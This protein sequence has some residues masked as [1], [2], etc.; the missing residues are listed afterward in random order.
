MRWVYVR[1]VCV[2]VA[3]CVLACTVLSTA[4]MAENDM[5]DMVVVVWVGARALHVC[6]VWEGN[7]GLCKK[8]R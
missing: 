7:C 3:V 1:Y 2:C 5:E 6:M 4:M 8:P